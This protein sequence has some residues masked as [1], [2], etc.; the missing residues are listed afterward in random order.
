M[1]FP[2]KEISEHL[3]NTTKLTNRRMQSSLSL[4][5]DSEQFIFQYQKWNLGRQ[6]NLRSDAVR[7]ALS[8]ETPDNLIGFMHYASPV[9]AR[10]QDFPYL[11]GRN[12]P[13]SIFY[14]RIDTPL[15][16]NDNRFFKQENRAAFFV[17]PFFTNKEQNYKGIASALFRLALGTSQT[18]FEQIPKPNGSIHYFEVH[19]DQRSPFGLEQVYQNEVVLFPLLEF[20]MGY[21]STQNIPNIN[22]SKIR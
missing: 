7:I 6:S 1:T 11:I 14:S 18:L 12:R 2:V 9:E 21:V 3:V 15:D 4:D 8:H 13:E 17:D 20:K 16:P 19:L 10:P 22:I 5:V